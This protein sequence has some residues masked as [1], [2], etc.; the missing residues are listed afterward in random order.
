MNAL[1]SFQYTLTQCKIDV[2]R[3]VCSIVN[4]CNLAGV[5]QENPADKPCFNVFYMFQWNNTVI[6]GSG[7]AARTPRAGMNSKKNHVTKKMSSSTVLV[8]SRLIP[9]GA[10]ERLRISD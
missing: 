10:V 3:K 9:R 5:K 6:Q 7:W 8:R 4:V 2:L 1:G